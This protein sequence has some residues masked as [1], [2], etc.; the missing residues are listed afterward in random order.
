LAENLAHH[1]V[2]GS[3]H[4]PTAY[5]PPLY[6]LLL[7]PCT[8][9]GPLERLAIAALHV[10][11]GLA[12][13]GLVYHLG[14]RWGL[15]R[16]ALLA[17]ALV[18]CDP[19]LLVQ[20]TLVMTETAA[21]LLAVLAL[22]LLT[23]ASERPSAGRAMAA[24][25]C[26]ALAVLCRATFLPWAV[27]AALVLPAMAPTWSGRLKLLASFLAAGAIVLAPWMVRNQV[28]FGRPIVATTHGGYTLL[29]ANN[30]S[31]YEYLR[32]GPWGTVWDADPFN[33]EWSRRAA[34]GGPAEEIENDRRAYAEA[35]QNI[36][37]EPGMFAYSCLVRA[38]RLW[39]PLPHQVDPQ[40]GPAKRWMRYLVG[41]WYLVELALAG[42]GLVAL[43]KGRAGPEEP[44][45]TK[46]LCEN[47]S[48][49]APLPASG[50][51]GAGFRIGSRRHTGT[52][53]RAGIRWWRTG[54]L[55]GILLAGCFTAVHAVYWS[56]LR[57]R[58][59]L[60]PAVALAAA[61]G[62]S[63]L[64]ACVMKRNALRIHRLDH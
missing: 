28:R 35:W 62:A 33:R 20:S 34:R 14:R 54:W 10:G 39:A 16:F 26:L 12:T 45:R 44:A 23:S 50:A 9:L 4:R 43:S 5:R 18:A 52:Q 13:V 19:I 48:P 60:M 38:G 27:V 51:R 2:F 64:A 22:V 37:R 6:P 57:M 40:E 42:A 31:F 47:P 59:P 25:A 63:W 8:A 1:G 36:R 29:L 30:P 24:G 17:A 55:W 58:A 53:A 15:G 32:H 41:L 21:T 3:G 46:S 61:A 7:A 56:N 49:P 11:L